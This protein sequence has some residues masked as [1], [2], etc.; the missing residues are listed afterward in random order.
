MPLK[1]IDS[2]ALAALPFGEPDAGKVLA[3][4][5]GSTFAAPALF[6]FEIASVCLKKMRLHPERRD[7]LLSAFQ[8]L[9]EMEIDFVDVDLPGCGIARTGNVTNPIRFH[10]SLARES[11]RL[12]SR[13]A[14]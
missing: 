11:A 9:P 8:A 4:I 6:P 14:G 10:L 2:S 1:V 12:R 3:R 13:H 7:L 5:E